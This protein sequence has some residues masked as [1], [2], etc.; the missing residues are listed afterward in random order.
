MLALLCGSAMAGDIKI[1]NIS[2]PSTA[3]LE[4][5]TALVLNGAGIRKKLF[6]K[7]YV[8][9]L[10][11]EQKSNNPELIISSGQSSRVLMH[12]VYDG[13][14]KKK[15]TDAW[16]TGFEKNHSAEELIKLKPRIEKFNNMFADTRA[17][18]VILL[19]YL[20]GQGT[21]VSINNKQRGSIAGDDF[22]KALMRIWL[23]KHPVTTS[24]K[25]ALL[26]RN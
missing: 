18:D 7:I 1:A 5:G 11:L 12:F 3:T 17:D 23:G 26:G 13:V 19:D 16:T 8:G 15:I 21:I 24:L 2:L 9:A 22:N 14:S 10:Y 25:D 6:I 4:S 20:P